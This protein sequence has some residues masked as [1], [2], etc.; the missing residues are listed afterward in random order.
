MFCGQCRSENPDHAK[1]CWKCSADLMS[2][3]A[4]GTPAVPQQ[5]KVTLPSEPTKITTPVDSSETPGRPLSHAARAGIFFALAF[6]CSI[7]GSFALKSIFSSVITRSNESFAE[8]NSSVLLWT[9]AGAWVVTSLFPKRWRTTGKTCITAMVV[10]GAVLALLAIILS[11][12]SSATPAAQEATPSGQDSQRSDRTFSPWKANPGSSPAVPDRSTEGSGPTR[13]IPELATAFESRRRFAHDLGEQEF[14]YRV[15]GQGGRMHHAPYR[16]EA[17]N[18][19]IFAVFSDPCTQHDFDAQILMV[20]G[21]MAREVMKRN[22]KELGFTH[23]GAKCFSADRTQSFKRI[24]SFD[25]IVT[26]PKWMT[27]PPE[28]PAK[29]EERPKGCCDCSPELT[30]NQCFMKCNAMI[31]RCIK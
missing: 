12:A 11:Q 19:T 16:F 23:F 3:V 9:G 6:I 30:D 1:Y 14:Q 2:G 10:Y 13:P 25:E 29:V 5:A 21:L 15:D 27:D 8:F 26:I 17:E 20:E 28:S 22:C 7:V 24:T 31:P 4:T 18:T